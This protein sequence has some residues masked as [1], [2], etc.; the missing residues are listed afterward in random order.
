MNAQETNEFM[1]GVVDRLKKGQNPEAEEDYIYALNV[2]LFL[3][4]T[5][6]PDEEILSKVIKPI[7][8]MVILICEKFTV[9]HPACKESSVG[10]KSFEQWYREARI[11]LG[12]KDRYPDYIFN[13]LQE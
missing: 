2:L 1:T 8:D 5:V 4:G 9:A 12:Y 13:S 7:G 10:Q 6:K 3:A 11:K